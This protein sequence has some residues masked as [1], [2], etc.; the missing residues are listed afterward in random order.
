M[1]TSAPTLT[2]AD[3]PAD[4]VELTF[5]TDEQTLADNAVAN[6]QATWTD[7]QPNDGDVEVVLIETL[8][9]YASASAQQASAMPGEAFIALTTKLYGIPF[10]EGAPAQTTIALTFQ[11]AAGGYYVPA[12]SE[13][14][15]SGYAFSTVLDVTSTPGS[16]TVDGVQIVANDVGVA[17]NDLTDS[18]WSSITLPVWVIDLATDAP[19]S[20]GV[21]PQATYDYLNMASRELQIRGRMIVTLPDFEIAAVNTPGVGRAYAH[22]DSARNVTVT[23]TD[24][25]GQPVAP[26]VKTALQAVYQAATLVNVTFN[27]ADATYTAVAVNYEVMRQPGFDSTQLQ[28]SIN[29]TLSAWLSPTGYGAVSGLGQPGSGTASWLPDNTVRLNKVVSTI[30]N[31]PGVA[32]VVANSVKLNGAA[33]DLVLPGT[34]ALPTPGVM[35]GIVDTPPA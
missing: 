19:T 1:S 4:Y 12:G 34:V 33:A 22:A 30:G 28:Q 10:A 29:A 8:A 27:L 7:W 20:G 16:D 15:L 9:P 32:Y 14:E 11:D 6:L 35:T 24:S 17:F 26:S 3:Y 13:F 25:N 21:D 5:T 18:N 31:V 2:G 23:L